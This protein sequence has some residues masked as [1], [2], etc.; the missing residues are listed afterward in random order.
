MLWLR[1]RGGDRAKF[2]TEVKLVSS[3][4][5]P[6]EGVLFFQSKVIFL[7]PQGAF[8]PHFLCWNPLSPDSAMTIPTASSLA[9]CHFLEASPSLLPQPRSSW[10]SLGPFCARNPCSLY[11]ASKVRVSS[12]LGLEW[13][14]QGCFAT[15]RTKEALREYGPR[16]GV[17]KC[18]LTARA[19]PWRWGD[20]T[21]AV[22]ET[23][24]GDGRRKLV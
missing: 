11:R 3:G 5:S 20:S 23:Q 9:R 10:C 14:A 13:F 6:A 4:Q 24:R 1:D 21:A 16:A 22:W 2:F 8:T 19:L 17:T 15:P 12:T 18:D 7:F